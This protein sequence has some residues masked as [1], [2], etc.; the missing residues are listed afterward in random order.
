ME[1]TAAEIETKIDEWLTLRASYV[2]RGAT[3]IVSF[4]DDEVAKLR[5][6]LDQVRLPGP[7]A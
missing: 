1:R 5:R 4:I 3:G 7:E 6:E 2:A